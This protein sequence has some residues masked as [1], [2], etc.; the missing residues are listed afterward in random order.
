MDKVFIIFER[1]AWHSG[2]FVVRRYRD[3]VAEAHVFAFETVYDALWS[4][5]EHGI[6]VKIP[7]PDWME[8]PDAMYAFA[9]QRSR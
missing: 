8:D 4:I 5:D 1:P 3:G 6:Y 9:Q 2:R 7:M